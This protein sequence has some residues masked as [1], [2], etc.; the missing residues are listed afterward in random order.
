V[1]PPRRVAVSAGPVSPPI[2]ATLAL[3]GQARTL[4]RLDRA[5]AV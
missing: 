2:E 5:L 4:A 3:R 1:A